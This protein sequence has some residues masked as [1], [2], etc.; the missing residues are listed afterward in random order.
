MSRYLD[1]HVVRGVYRDARRD[2]PVPVVWLWGSGGNGEDRVDTLCLEVRGA[3]GLR[4]G[5]PDLRRR[6]G[7]ALRVGHHLSRQVRLFCST[8]ELS[9]AARLAVRCPGGEAPVVVTAPVEGRCR[10]LV[11]RVARAV[12][13]RD[14][15]PAPRGWDG[16]READEFHLVRRQALA[17]AEASAA[18]A[19]APEL[20]RRPEPASGGSP[21]PLRGAVVRAI[22]DLPPVERI[23]ACADALAAIGGSLAGMPSGPDATRFS[24]LLDA[25]GAELA[26][27]LVEPVGIGLARLLALD[28]SDWDPVDATFGDEASQEVASHPSYRGRHVS[29]GGHLPGD[30]LPS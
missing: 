8:P 9:Q 18:L 3:A 24:Q 4:P 11:G 21:R 5:D 2:F 15:H 28:A 25:F 7:D 14:G 19:L 12:L 20:V 29:L 1:V 22:R 10:E 23:L 17:D 13:V 27:R 16:A 26:G 30:D 6:F